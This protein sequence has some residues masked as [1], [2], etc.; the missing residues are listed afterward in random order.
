M[1]REEQNVQEQYAHPRPNPDQRPPN[2]L[3]DTR[4]A[5]G[6]ELYIHVIY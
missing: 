3:P 6:N 1:W 2:P 5:T 4:P